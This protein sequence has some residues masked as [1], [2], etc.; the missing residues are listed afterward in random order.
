M[1]PLCGASL[2]ITGCVLDLNKKKDPRVNHPKMA[3][4][5]GKAEVEA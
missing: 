5:W 2:N 3:F 4:G 1:C